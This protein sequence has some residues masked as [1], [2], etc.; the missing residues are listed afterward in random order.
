MA[1]PHP[2]DAM[3]PVIRRQA[4]ADLLRQRHASLFRN[5]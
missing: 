3:D 2:E 1:P 4:L 5:L